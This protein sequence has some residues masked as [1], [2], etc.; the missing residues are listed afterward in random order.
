M[1]NAEFYKKI[2]I[3]KKD[4]YS[5]AIFSVDFWWFYIPGNLLIIILAPFFRNNR[6]YSRRKS[7]FECGV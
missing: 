2:Q 1:K 7:I 4:L 6:Q 5:P 3:P